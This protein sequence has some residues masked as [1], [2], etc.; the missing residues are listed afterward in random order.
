VVVP[1]LSSKSIKLPKASVFIFSNPIE[2]KAVEKLLKAS[3]KSGL[4]TLR[5]KDGHP[6]SDTNALKEE[7]LKEAVE[8]IKKEN[9]K[10]SRAANKNTSEKI[11]IPKIPK[12]ETVSKTPSHVSNPDSNSKYSPTQ[13]TPPKVQSIT[14]RG[15]DMPSAPKPTRKEYP[16]HMQAEM[17]NNQPVVTIFAGGKMDELLKEN[18]YYHIGASAAAKVQNWTGL[19]NLLEMM[20]ENFVVPSDLQR[21]IETMI[22]LMKTNKNQLMRVKPQQ[23]AFARKFYN[24][25]PRKQKIDQA[26][27]S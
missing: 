14:T 13:S 5:L 20:R 25:N 9:P 3:G 2:E 1:G 7:H 26:P 12:V 4:S 21:T 17:L 10:L 24:D 18:G 19:K 6:V 23:F 8:N 11:S 22:Q 15:K 16:Y 27:S